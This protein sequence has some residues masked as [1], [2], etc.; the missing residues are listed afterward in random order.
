MKDT[1]LIKK[2]SEEVQV[3]CDMNNLKKLTKLVVTVNYKSN[4]NEEHLRKQLHH[5]NKKTF[6]PWTQIQVLRDDIQERT[7]ILHTVEGEKDD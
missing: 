1:Y 5:M 6:G 2:I 4:I 7:A 3:L